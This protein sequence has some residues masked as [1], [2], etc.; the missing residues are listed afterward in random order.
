MSLT[1]IAIQTVHG[2]SGF[3]GPSTYESLRQSNCTSCLVK[4]DLSNYWFP[5]LYFH[6][7]AANK[8]EEVNNGGLLIYYQ[9]RGDEDVSN[10]GPGIVAFP[11]GLKMI[12]GSP[13]RRSH[14]Y[15]SKLLGTLSSRAHAIFSD[16]HGATHLRQLWTRGLSSSPACVTPLGSQ[17]TT[18]RVVSRR[19]TARVA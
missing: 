3:K 13:M 16:I 9:N 4:E 7:R 8:F 1:Y 6:D 14:K 15:I 10:G 17:V 2:A 12:S 19:P 5:K 11:P 18:P